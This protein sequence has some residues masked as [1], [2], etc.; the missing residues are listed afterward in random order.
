M[1]PKA[2]RREKKAEAERESSQIAQRLLEN[3]VRSQ[4]VK[5]ALGKDE[6]RKPW[7]R[8]SRDNRNED[9]FQLEPLPEADEKG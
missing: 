6:E 3:L 9:M 2:A 1:F 7:V 4:A 8:K 5:G